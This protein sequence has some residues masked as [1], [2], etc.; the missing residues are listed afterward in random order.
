MTNK[1][2]HGRIWSKTVKKD[3]E[4]VELSVTLPNNVESAEVANKITEVL[5]EKVKDIYNMDNLRIID[6]AKIPDKPCNINPIKYAGIGGIIGLFFVCTIILIMHICDDSIKSDA[7]VENKIKLPV[8]A[9]FRKQSNS[10]ISEWNP[11]LDYVEAFKVLRTNIQFSKQ[12]LNK[13]TIAV[14]SCFPGEGKSWVASNLAIAFSK[15]DYRVLVVDADLRKGVQHL[16]FEVNRKPG[17]IQLIKSKDAIEG[18]ES[19]KKYITKTKFK[20][21]YLLPSGGN[22]SD[23]SELLLSNKIQ[24]IIDSLKGAFDII[25]FDS[26]PGALVSD[27]SVLSRMVD[28][29]IIVIESEKTRIRDLK[30]V[31]NSIENVGGGISG[32]VINK[33]NN[34]KSKDY[35]YYG[36][37]E[38]LPSVA[39][40][41]HFNNMELKNRNME[42]YTP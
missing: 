33:V 4:F 21:I 31:K 34:K 28:S 30:K 18:F 17:L 3:T 38:N 6:S 14:S 27:A 7:D 1:F 35:Y 16:K 24:Y 2:R 23:S 8:L 37:K 40:A 11:R 39:R 22:I 20:N 13:K 42:D 12:M 41:K 25:I 5:D 19:C 26:T 29:N 32:V 15:A 10:A 36:Y 9:T